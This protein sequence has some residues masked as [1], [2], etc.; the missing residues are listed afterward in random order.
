[1]GRYIVYMGTSLGFDVF[2]LIDERV[3]WRFR[4]ERQR[5]EH[6]YGWHDD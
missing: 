3:L 5:D 4:A 2:L 6:E 1:M